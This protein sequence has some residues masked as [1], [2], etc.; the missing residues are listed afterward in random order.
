MASAVGPGEYTILNKV[1]ASDGSRLAVTFN[2]RGS[3][4]PVLKPN[5]EIFQTVSLL[6][7]GKLI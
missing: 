1:Q 5:G 4:L 3:P 7:V 6:R 2:Q